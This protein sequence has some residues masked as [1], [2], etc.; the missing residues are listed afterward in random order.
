VA[1][2]CRGGWSTREVT[3]RRS[4][5]EA[6]EQRSRSDGKWHLSDAPETDPITFLQDYGF[7]GLTIPDPNGVAGQGI[8]KAVGPDG[9]PMMDDRAIAGSAP[10]SG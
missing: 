8:G 4:T 3:Y 9:L 10:S 2:R 7:Q 5:C 6:P 1:R